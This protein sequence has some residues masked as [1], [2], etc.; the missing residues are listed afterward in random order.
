VI[1]QAATGRRLA[2][3]TGLE[4]TQV[5][6]P[7]GDD[8]L[9]F[10]PDG[11]LLAKSMFDGS[12]LILNP[13]T[14]RLMQALASAAGTTSLAFAPDGTL[15][16]GT[17][18]GTVEFWTPITGKEIGSPLVVASNAVASISFDPTAPLLATAGRGEGTVKLWFTGTLEQQGSALTTDPGASSSVTFEPSGDRLLAFADDGSGFAW[19]TS[20]SAWEHRACAVAGRNL[21]RREWSQLVTGHGYATVCP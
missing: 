10:S 18:A 6:Q 1:W 9:A 12:I 14:G 16:A 19:P 8:L 13:P 11:K 20:V 7:S 4:G 2:S 5:A 3:P 17:P 21:T 15:A